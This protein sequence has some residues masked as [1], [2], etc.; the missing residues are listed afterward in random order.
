MQHPVAGMPRQFLA[1]VPRPARWLINIL[2]NST[3][4]SSQRTL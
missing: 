4:L 1:K 3:A 2:I